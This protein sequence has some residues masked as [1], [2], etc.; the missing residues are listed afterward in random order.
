MFCILIILNYIKKIRVLIKFKMVIK[1]S[2]Q[3]IR[4]NKNKL[5]I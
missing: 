2:I 4:N 5:K 1:I 3:N